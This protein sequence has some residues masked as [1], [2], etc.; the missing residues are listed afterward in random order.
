MKKTANS[1]VIYQTE[2]G[3]LEL[4][5]DTK[6]ETIWLTQQQVANLF[7]VKKATI[8]KHVKNIC[9][10]KELAQKATV[11]KMEIVQL[12]GKRNI[13]RSKEYYNLDLVLSIDY[14]VN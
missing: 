7:D 10:S 9:D 4:K 5:T 13:K 8:S 12:E 1:I 6:R 2:A 11:S 14:R 3:S